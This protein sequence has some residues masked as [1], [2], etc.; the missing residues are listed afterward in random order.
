MITFGPAAGGVSVSFNDQPGALY[1]PALDARIFGAYRLQHGDLEKVG[2]L[3]RS[4]DVSEMWD[5]I[6]ATIAIDRDLF[7]RYREFS[8]SLYTTSPFVYQDINSQYWPDSD[9]VAR[10][11]IRLIIRPKATALTRQN[12]T[13]EFAYNQTTAALSL[14]ASLGKETAHM[15]YYRVPATNYYGTF[16]EV[17]QQPHANPTYS[18]KD[19]EVFDWRKPGETAECGFWQARRRIRIF[20]HSSGGYDVFE[21]SSCAAGTLSLNFRG[22]TV[23]PNDNANNASLQQTVTYTEDSGQLVFQQSIRSENVRF[24]DEFRDGEIP[25]TR[26]VFSLTHIMDPNIP[27]SVNYSYIHLDPTTYPRPAQFRSVRFRRVLSPLVKGQYKVDEI[28][29]SLRTPAGQHL[30]I[31]VSDLG[32]NRYRWRL[33]ENGNTTDEWLMM[34]NDGCSSEESEDLTEMDRASNPDYWQY[35]EINGR[36]VAKAYRYEQLIKTLIFYK[37]GITSYIRGEI[38]A[39]LLLAVQHL[40]IVCFANDKG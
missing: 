11:G 2:S 26:L 20:P 4:V 7:G 6:N 34:F 25:G 22:T 40:P 31:T 39:S 38:F 16:E 17:D 23:F 12:L 35:S 3:L 14:T 36:V 21:E 33:R 28:P 5:N 19:L 37:D 15:S 32:H 1:K 30:L 27:L 24:R 10:S 9:Q 29:G 13:M 8:M 18:L